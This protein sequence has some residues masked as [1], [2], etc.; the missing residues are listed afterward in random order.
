MKIVYVDP[1]YNLTE[2]NEKYIPVKTIEVDETIHR[3][4]KREWGVFTTYTDLTGY[5][6][7]SKTWLKT[8]KKAL[9]WIEIEKQPSRP[10]YLNHSSP[11]YVSLC[12]VLYGDKTPEVLI[13][14][15]ENAPEQEQAPTPNAENT[16]AISTQKIDKSDSKTEQLNL[17]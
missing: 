9:A 17:F 5:S 16:I 2:Y 11:E 14:P 15:P 12:F 13:D 6:Y 4:E 7:T 8:Q 1:Q 10:Y 3:N